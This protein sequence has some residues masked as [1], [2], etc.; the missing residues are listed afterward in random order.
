M[1]GEA[2]FLRGQLFQKPTLPKADLT[3]QTIIVT[4]A[5]TGLGLDASKHL[6]R[7]NVSY[8]ILACRSLSKGE[9]AKEQILTSVRKSNTKIEV[10]PLDLCSYASVLD[11]ATRCNT[12][13]RLD[14]R[15]RERRRLIYRVQPCRRQ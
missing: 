5:N 14:G 6:V 13:S 9:A 2:Q 1:P 12:L 3:G 4:G 8:L 10:W 11:F 15:D 7:L